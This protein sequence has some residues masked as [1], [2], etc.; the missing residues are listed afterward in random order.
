VVSEADSA[1][2]YRHSVDVKA[3]GLVGS[4]LDATA[5]AVHSRKIRWPDFTARQCPAAVV[6]GLP[7]PDPPFD[8]P[9]RGRASDL[10]GP[11]VKPAAGHV[12]RECRLE[13]SLAFD[14]E[15]VTVG[16]DVF[17]PHHAVGSNGRRARRELLGRGVDAA[18]LHVGLVPARQEACSYAFRNRRRQH[19][20]TRHDDARRK[21]DLQRTTA[22][23]CVHPTFPR[24]ESFGSDTHPARLCGRESQA[25]AAV[26]VLHRV[27]PLSR[28]DGS[29]PGPDSIVNAATGWPP[30]V[31]TRP[32][33]T[34][35]RA[36]VTTSDSGFADSRVIPS[37]CRHDAKKNKQAMQWD[38]RSRILM[39]GSPA[40]LNET[41]RLWTT[42][43]MAAA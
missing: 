8:A 16:A 3:A 33:S 21:A 1:Q 42:A 7:T 29:L 22:A 20:A 28:S 2:A 34:A 17:E 19:D 9:R 38:R 5:I 27:P 31:T 32:V 11:H 15:P 13:N 30:G 24:R 14:E 10:D 43:S 6:S 25:E 12:D 37:A 18:S 26:A 41:L 35:D 23:F 39:A 4:K 36:C 40:G